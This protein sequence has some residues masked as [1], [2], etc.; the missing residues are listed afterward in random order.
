M[1][2]AR[3]KVAQELKDFPNLIAQKDIS[4]SW[5]QK[6]LEKTTPDKK[7]ILVK[8]QSHAIMNHLQYL[9]S[10]PTR[11]I[12][13]I[14]HPREVYPS[15]KNMTMRRLDVA[16]TKSWEEWH[17][18]D[19]IPNFPVK[20]FFQIHHRLWK[21]FRN[22]AD[23]QPVIVDGHD[24]TTKPEVILP[25]LF[26]KLEIPY[27]ESYLEW[28]EGAEILKRKWRGSADIVLLDQFLAVYTQA[29]NSSKFELPKFPRGTPSN[30]S[31]K[32]TP[33]LDEVIEGALPYYIEMYEARL[34]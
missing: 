19:D 9:P 27:K 11:H 10:V 4:Y 14:R 15:W 34:Q 6:Q 8:D 7:F 31:W 16:G 21:H 33:D 22:N 2:A 26:G 24:L 3:E 20:D 1:K 32:I 29:T 13:I 17:V 23:F 18:A 25:K 12:F 5:L 30:P 28:E